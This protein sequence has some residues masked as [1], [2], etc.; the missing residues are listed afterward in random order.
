MISD[1]FESSNPAG[2]PRRVI[3]AF[4]L[5]V[6]ALLA[7]GLPEASSTGPTFEDDTT[8]RAVPAGRK[9][10]KVAVIP[11][12]GPID[13]VTFVSLQRRLQVAA[14]RNADA[15]V[16]ELDTPGGSLESTFEILELV[17]TT[18]PPN[19]VAWVRPKAFSAG[20]I[21]A[22]AT[23]EIITTPTGVF[24]DA[25]PIQAVPLAGLQQL[26]AA[27]RA[28]IEAPLLS[29]LVGDA[30]R[31]GWDEKLVQAFVAV[32]VEL[33]LIRNR[34]TGQRLFVDADE[35]QRIFGEPP[36]STRIKRL[37]APPAR[38]ETSGLLR[39]AAKI[40]QGEAP[41]TRQE[42]DEAIEFV[43]ELPSR[44]PILGPE[45][46]AEWIPLGQV[47]SSDELL[48]LRSDEA[49]AYGFSS[50]EI[51]TE[52]ELQDFFGASEIIRIDESWSEGLVRFLTLWPVRA[53]L[54][55]TLLIGFFIEAAAPGYGIFG[56]IA[57]VSL[58]VLL[59]APL[60]AG[61]SDW[62]TVLAVILGLGLIAVELFLL[63]GLGAPGII[64]GLLVFAGLVG[65][66]VSGDPLSPDA[67]MDLFRGLAATSIGFLGAG[68]GIWI[69]WRFIPGSSFG[70]RFVLAADIGPR[71]AGVTEPARVGTH[72]S[73]IEPGT[74]G[75][76]ATPLRTAGRVEF[77]GRLVDARSNG[78]F[79]ETNVPVRVVESDR[80]GVVVEAVDS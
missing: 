54:I 37:P 40:R 44:R 69:A 21:I 43:Q 34:E 39:G 57:L 76:S 42:R 11:I 12:H 35:Y 29:E 26:P 46:A 65:T 49:I 9:A 58:A 33:W 22:L 25:A 68:A 80:F 53:V 7:A 23:R 47:V 19:T 13:N 50:G 72:E 28:K 71:G 3:L 52:Q 74:I 62:W 14:D 73:P 45:D 38:D 70:R 56:L 18:A 1:G 55:A 60:L 36:V 31:Q 61:L 16:L 78:A 30:R 20:T 5:T 17:R 67:R 8:L 32:D 79:I 59:G 15:V 64:G 10:S 63:P 6:S 4:L 2:T 48:V 51:S 66:F 41:T 27:E 24:G 77:G 75:L